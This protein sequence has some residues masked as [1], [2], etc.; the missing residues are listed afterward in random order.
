MSDKQRQEMTQLGQLGLIPFAASAVIVWSSPWLVPQHVA[1]DFHFIALVYGATIVSYLAGIGAGSMLAPSAK[2]A[3][4]FLPSMLVT[5][6]AFYAATPSG[7]FYVTL[8]P[9]WKHLIIILLLIYLLIRDL[10]GVAAGGLPRWY[11][12][13]RQR[14]TFWASTFLALIMARLLLWGMY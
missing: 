7:V 4:P 1:L 8:D 6:V 3:R 2:G 5:L 10:N 11:A 12:A 13:L 14:L 9:A